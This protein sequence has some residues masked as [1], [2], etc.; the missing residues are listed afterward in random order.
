MIRFW[1]W[2]ESGKFF[3]IGLLV[4]Y[5]SFNITLE[6]YDMVQIVMKKFKCLE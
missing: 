5:I 3:D 4:F 2:V 1:V 6:S